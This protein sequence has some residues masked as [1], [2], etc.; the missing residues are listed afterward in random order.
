M[1]SKDNIISKIYFDPGGFG[2]IKQTFEDARKKDKSFTLDDVKEFFRTR[3][4]KKNKVY[5]FNSFVAP[6]PYYEYQADLFFINDLEN[7]KFKAAMLMIDIFTKYMVVVPLASKS[8]KTGDITSA[9]LECLN[10]MGKN[11]EIVYTDNEL[12][13]GTDAVN[14]LLKEKG[15][16]HIITRSKAWF[17][18]R[19]VRTFKNALYK[20]VENSKK[21]NVQWTDFIYPILLTYNNKIKHSTTNHTPE[22]AR[23]EKNELSVKLNLLLHKKQTRVYPKLKVNDEVKVLKKK[24][25]NQQKERY[26]TYLD[27]SYKIKKIT[28]EH[29]INHFL[30]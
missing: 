3:V 1:S 12:G 16:D 26:S 29:I 4:E 20:R 17:A 23:N 2:S 7:Q 15:I 25:L 27:N 21:Q 28:Y 5:G 18:E 11:P 24:T 6:R 8:E 9:L 10:K 30:N 19:A 22:E 13:L 14:D